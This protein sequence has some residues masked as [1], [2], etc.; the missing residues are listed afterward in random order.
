VA[1]VQVLKPK[2]IEH[3]HNDAL[4]RSLGQSW[5]GQQQDAGGKK[6]ASI[7]VTLHRTYFHTYVLS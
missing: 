5:R 4:L 6:I 2:S 3:Q 7:H 1:L